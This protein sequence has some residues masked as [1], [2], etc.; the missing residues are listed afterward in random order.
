MDSN[1]PAN[2][3]ECSVRNARFFTDINLVSVEWKSA[4][5]SF[6]R[7]D[8]SKKYGTRVLTLRNTTP[9]L[10]WCFVFHTNVHRFTARNSFELLCHCWFYF[11]L[12]MDRFNLLCHLNLS[13][14]REINRVSRRLKKIFDAAA[15]KR[16][17]VAFQH[18]EFVIFRRALSSAILLLPIHGNQLCVSWSRFVSPSQNVPL[19][20]VPG[21]SHTGKRIPFW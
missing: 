5:V 1:L 21:K 11:L 12:N 20:S 6:E 18:A 10:N 4:A 15:N 7:W 8:C 14:A 16:V 3:A 2:C 19:S 13:P 17:C 9:A